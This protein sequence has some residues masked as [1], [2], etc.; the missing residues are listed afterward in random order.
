MKMDLWEEEGEMIAA[1]ASQCSESWPQI[2]EPGGRVVRQDTGG[3]RGGGRGEADR[4]IEARGGE[5][6][7]DRGG[8]AF[9]QRRRQKYV[10]IAQIPTGAVREERGK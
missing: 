10:A 3:G 2:S 6:A 7:I 5:R 1:A 4:W 9:Q 8:I